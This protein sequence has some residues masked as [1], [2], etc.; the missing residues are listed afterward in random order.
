MGSGIARDGQGAALE[1]RVGDWNTLGADA[2]AVRTEVFVREQGIPAELE[3]DEWDALSIHC[4]AYDGGRAVATGRLLPDGHI[5][6]MAVL[7]DARRG[8]I[9]GRVL[10]RLIEAAV[11]RGD[12]EVLLN[13]QAY[14]A[15]FY[16]R[17]GFEAFGEPFDEV[18]IPHVAMRR[19]LR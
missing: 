17:H 8:G 15:G 14:V 12:A 19:A 10:Q 2:G 16:R 9:G 13:A 4:V 3:W 11:A 5:G 7:A 1:L 18:G 6:R